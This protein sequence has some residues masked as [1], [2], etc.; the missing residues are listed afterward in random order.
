MH[1][2]PPAKVQV[3]RWLRVLSV[4]YSNV[5][6]RYKTSNLLLTGI[7]LG[8]K[9]PSPDQVQRY[10]RPLINDL[11]RLWEDGIIVKMPRNSNGQRVQVALLCVIC[12]APAAHKLGGFGSHSHTLFCTQ[13]WVNLGSKQDA[14]ALRTDGMVFLCFSLFSLNGILPRISSM[15]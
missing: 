14:A 5:S 7:I 9:E 3:S 11:L 4:D 12:D 15:D 1:S 10:M 8:P 13:C 2:Q 6:H